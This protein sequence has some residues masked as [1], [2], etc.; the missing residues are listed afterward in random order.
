ML[1]SGRWE[2]NTAKILTELFKH[3]SFV[4]FRQFLPGD[5]F[6]TWQNYASTDKNR[7]DLIAGQVLVIVVTLSRPLVLPVRGIFF[8]VGR[9]LMAGFE[10]GLSPFVTGMEP[11][12]K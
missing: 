11:N 10:S 1:M 9:G 3:V 5:I 8:N 6:H 12:W 2:F 4:L 7:G